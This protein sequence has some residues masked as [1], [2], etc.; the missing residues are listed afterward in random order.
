MINST[1]NFNQI[2]NDLD[3]EISNFTDNI[4]KI[5]N[6]NSK[7]V[8]PITQYINNK[9]KVI[10]HE[11]NVARR[12]WQTTRNPAFKTL[13]NRLHRQAIKLEQKIKQDDWKDKLIA[14][15]PDDNTLWNTAKHMRKQHTKI[16]ALKGQSSIALSNSEKSETLADS[17]EN[18]FTLNNMTTQT[19]KILFTT[20][21][22]NS[23]TPP[24]TPTSPHP[25]SP[26]C[27]TTPTK[28]TSEKPQALTESQI[29]SLEI[30]PS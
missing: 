11:R 22:K 16:S 20:Q 5:F 28:L 29:K 6:S 17:L 14:L 9:V 23:L 1:Y 24:L 21:Y 13:Y 7:I 27:Y 25:L 19:Q 8:D 10:H 4:N 12:K 18:Q 3:N 15:E 30:S 26:N 2:T